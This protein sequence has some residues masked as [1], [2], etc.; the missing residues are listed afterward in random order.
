MHFNLGPTDTLC[1]SI[2]VTGKCNLKCSYCHFYARHNREKTHSDIANN[3]FDLYLETILHIKTN[4]HENIQIRFSGGDPLM[5]NDNLFRLSDKVYG[6][7]GIKP[8]ILTNGVNIGDWHI[9]QAIQNHIAAYLISLENPLDIDNGSI[10]PQKLLN[11]IKKYHSNLLEV[12]PAVVIVKNHMF[13]KLREICDYFYEIIGR[14]P[15]VSELSFNY[16]QSPSDKELEA[17]GNNVYE[18]VTKYFSKTPLELFPYII[19]ELAYCYENKYLIELDLDNSLGITAANISEKCLFFLN[20]HLNNSYP[21][22]DCTDL[23]CD[24]RL[25]CERVKWVWKNKIIDYCRMKKVISSAYY[26]ALK[27]A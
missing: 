7:L 4:Y 26:E 2:I 18:T 11:K 22:N 14:L 23:E 19:P 21:L 10:N 3:L 13:Y 17:L 5:L 8:Y 9:K 24:W 16:F 27:E 12:S 1:F 25:N 15:T 20:D 6:K